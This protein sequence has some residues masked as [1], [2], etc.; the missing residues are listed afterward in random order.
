M[1]IIDGSSRD[2]PRATV[3]NVEW[4]NG[5]ANMKLLLLQMLTS[6]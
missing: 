2:Y 4:G 1:Q 3:L 6:Q 5:G